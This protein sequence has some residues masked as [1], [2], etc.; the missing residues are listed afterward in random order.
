MNSAGVHPLTQG[1]ERSGAPQ[2]WRVAVQTLAT[3]TTRSQVGKMELDDVFYKREEINVEV[4]S[5]LNSAATP[6]GIEILRFEIQ[7]ITPPQAI[8]RMFEVV[9]SLFVVV[10][11]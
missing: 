7:Q 9:C 6:W 5:A 3:T 8:R 2:D 4:L 10:C 1:I 11:F